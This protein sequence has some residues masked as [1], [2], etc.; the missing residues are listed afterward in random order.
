MFLFRDVQGADLGNVVEMYGFADVFQLLDA[1]SDAVLVLPREVAAGIV[2][3]SW[4][5]KPPR[6]RDRDLGQEEK[7]WVCPDRDEPVVVVPRPLHGVEHLQKL[8]REQKPAVSTRIGGIVPGIQNRPRSTSPITIPNRN[9][10]A[11]D[12]GIRHRSTV[13][14]RLLS[15]DRAGMF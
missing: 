9:G 15:S 2:G 8:I 14:N 6:P 4:P 1:M 11:I 3:L 13:A 7:P 12:E 5:P 10:Q